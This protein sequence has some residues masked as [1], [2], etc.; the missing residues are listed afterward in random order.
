[1]TS[2]DDEI[3]KIA[4][5]ILAGLNSDPFKIQNL[6]QYYRLVDLLEMGNEV[7][8]ISCE[9][10]GYPG[11]ED[12]PS[13]RK[14]YDRH[15][16]TCASIRDN[17]ATLFIYADEGKTL[18][19]SVRNKHNILE[20]IYVNEYNFFNVINAVDNEIFR[21]TSQLLKKLK[22]EKIEEDILEETIKSVN[23]RLN[24]I[25]QKALEKLT[26]TY[27]DLINSESSLDLQQIAYS[28]RLVMQD[29][30]DAVFEPSKN[31]RLDLDNIP[32]AVDK[33]NYI[34]RIMAYVEDNLSSDTD[35]DLIKSQLRYLGE[36]LE[37]VYK[38]T[39]KGT[40]SEI[41]REHANRCVIYTY[42]ILGDIIRLTT[43][44]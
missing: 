36:F 20:N 41:N 29:F 39:N 18:F 21:K 40:H 11:K 9:L 23:E 17:Y 28:C 27:M 26:E 1:M 8:W 42:L 44:K 2:K 4:E 43:E 38:L 19:Y 33:Q 12:V 6:R 14:V 15:S 24:K 25:C 10:Y 32:H 5:S 22:F 31:K 3:I 13:Y 16:D 37:N 30:A 35:K 34:N 7:K